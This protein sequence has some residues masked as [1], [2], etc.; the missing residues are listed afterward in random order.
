MATPL[1]RAGQKIEYEPVALYNVGFA[2]GKPDIDAIRNGRR[3]DGPFPVTSHAIVLWVDAFGVQAGD[4]VRFLITGPDGRAVFEHEQRMQK[5]QA[6]SFQFAGGR[7][8]GN[9]TA[10]TYRGEV[11]LT[12]QGD[13]GRTIRARVTTSVALK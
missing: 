7:L 9:L 4:R 10:G 8:R 1:W 11:T 12:R 2:A 13:D 3:D 5:T 6:R